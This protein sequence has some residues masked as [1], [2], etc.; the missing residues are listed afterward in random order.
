[1]LSVGL[2]GIAA[3]QSMA[4]GRNVDAN[5]LSIVTNLAADMVERIQYNRPNVTAYAGIDTLNAGT[6]PPDTQPMARGDYDQW[7]A[8]LTATPLRGVRGLVSVTAIG[9]ANLNQ[10]Q[11]LVQVTWTGGSVGGM[12]LEGTMT[13]TAR[14]RAVSLGTV[15]A[16]E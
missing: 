13:R 14:T 4:L 7:S 12:A 10:S 1:V 11:V 2:L 8:R 6:R 15:I 5:E 3:M 16:P 9:P